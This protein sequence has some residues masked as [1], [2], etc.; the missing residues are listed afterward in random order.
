MIG[1]AERAAGYEMSSNNITEQGYVLPRHIPV[2][3]VF[4]LLSPS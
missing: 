2:S 3:I 4:P 1:A